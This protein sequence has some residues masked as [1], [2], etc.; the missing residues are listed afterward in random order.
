MSLLQELITY[1][2]DVINGAEVAC[3]KHKWACARFLNDL[4][5]KDFK[6]VF[7][8]EKA[9]RFL[10]WMRLFKHTKGVLQGENIEPHII[11]KFV[12][13]NIYGWVNKETGLRRFKKA[14]WQVGRKNAKSQSLGAM[15]SY[16]SMAFGENA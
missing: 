7:D 10:E 2:E 13:G 11:Q 9:E 16:E 4:N 3:I 1:S 6:Y 12:F 15:G 8:E 14:Y 5:K